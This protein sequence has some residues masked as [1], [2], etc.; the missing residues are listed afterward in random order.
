MLSWVFTRKIPRLQR[1][2]A[3]GPGRQA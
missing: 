3:P 1:W 2:S